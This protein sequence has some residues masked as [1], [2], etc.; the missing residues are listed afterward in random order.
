M[1]RVNCSKE[2]RPAPSGTP[3][4]SIR[5]TDTLRSWGLLGL[6]PKPKEEAKLP[7]DCGTETGTGILTLQVSQ[8]RVFKPGVVYCVFKH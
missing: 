3:A 8:K 1:S 4:G 5:P 6:K 2:R 7:K